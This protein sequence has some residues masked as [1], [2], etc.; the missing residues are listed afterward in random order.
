[1]QPYRPPLPHILR[2]RSIR[3]LDTQ[4]TDIWVLGIRHRGSPCTWGP[5]DIIGVVHFTALDTLATG[6]VIIIGNGL[7]SQSGSQEMFNEQCLPY[8]SAHL[9]IAMGTR[10]VPL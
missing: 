6:L 10:D 1:M 4:A 9:E 3:D 2:P 8:D 5:L 7:C